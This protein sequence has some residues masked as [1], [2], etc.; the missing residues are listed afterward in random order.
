GEIRAAHLVAVRARRPLP[1]GA[2]RDG[3][4]GLQGRGDLR[5]ARSP[6]PRV[7]GAHRPGTPL[8]RARPTEPAGGDSPPRAAAE[9]FGGGARGGGA[10]GALPRPPHGV[11]GPPGPGPPLPGRALRGLGGGVPRREAVA[12]GSGAGPGAEHNA[13]AAP[14]PRL[15]IVVDEFRVLADEYPD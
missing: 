10:L 1:T 15:L 14:L 13:R 4:R 3:P 8:H 12:E 6:A 7:G 5:G 2:R 9:G 11:E